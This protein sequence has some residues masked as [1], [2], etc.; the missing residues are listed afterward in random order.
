[1]SRSERTE[2]YDGPKSLPH[3]LIQ[4]MARMAC[5]D[6]IPH[7]V[8]EKENA[9]GKLCRHYSPIE[10]EV[11]V[12]M[13]KG[14]LIATVG[15]TWDGEGKLLQPNFVPGSD[16]ADFLRENFRSA[17]PPH[18]VL[19]HTRSRCMKPGD[20][21]GKR[22]GSRGGKDKSHPFLVVWVGQCAGCDD[23][24]STSYVAGF[25]E[26]DLEA[27]HNESNSVMVE[28]TMMIRGDGCVHPTDKKY[29]KLS[30]SSRMK[31][32]EK[33]R[34]S[35]DRLMRP[36]ALA[37]RTMMEINDVNFTVGNLDG[38]AATRQ[39]EYELN[40]EVK[41]LERKKWN[42]TDCQLTNCLNVCEKLKQ[43]DLDERRERDGDGY[44]KD[45]PGLVRSSGFDDGFRAEL[46]TK[47]SIELFNELLQLGFI[48]YFDGS[49]GLL[50][51]PGRGHIIHSRLS[52]NPSEIFLNYEDFQHSNKLH[53]SFVLA[54]HISEAQTGDVFASFF[55]S[56]KASCDSLTQGK[57][58][59]NP[60]LIG[61]DCAGQLQNGLIK[62]YARDGQA[63]T[64]IMWQNVVLCILRWWER[65]SEANSN[66]IETSKIAFDMMMKYVPLCVHECRS[67]VF[68]AVDGWP[69]DKKRP[70]DVTNLGQAL[71]RM[72]THLGDRMTSHPSICDAIAQLSYSI[73]ILEESHIS[74]PKFDDPDCVR[75]DI[76]ECEIQGVL[77]RMKEHLRMSA[78]L[79]H[80]HTRS[81]LRSTIKRAMKS[82]NKIKSQVFSGVE[83]AD[84]VL[85]E[86]KKTGIFVY[87]YVSSLSD[88][89][90]AATI[91]Y[92]IIYDVLGGAERLA[93]F[94]SPAFEL[95]T[96][97]PFEGGLVP[98]PLL[99][100]TAAKYLRKTWLKE[101]AL[102][103]RS[104]VNLLKTATGKH[105][106]DNNQHS[107]G[108]WRDTKQQPDL[109]ADCIEPARYFL[110][111][112][113]GF[114]QSCRM[115]VSDM[116]RMEI[117]IDNRKG[118][119]DDRDDQLL[120][121]SVEMTQDAIENETLMT[122]DATWDTGTSGKRY[123]T[124]LI[125]ALQ[126][127]FASDLGMKSV[128]GVRYT[129]GYDALK[130][131]VTLMGVGHLRGMGYKTFS[132]WMK[133]KRA[134]SKNVGKGN[135]AAFQDYIDKH[136]Q[137][138]GEK[139]KCLGCD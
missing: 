52:F 111:R 32:I 96:D 1:M 44:C 66:G 67:H 14:D 113:E 112:Y 27:L 6:A 15:L 20:I 121:E 90:N 48:G 129:A 54:E 125:W 24:C 4:K 80:I 40:R 76:D 42:L 131:H 51:L 41:E 57:E 102:W 75:N 109:K 74:L 139:C 46:Y 37:K 79:L 88:E 117:V 106:Y 43:I 26:G 35:A 83:V 133:G 97:Y 91:R 31:A 55:A 107:E 100:S 132:L 135:L 17:V 13:T 62:A 23:G 34:Y 25:R 11:I 50:H 53:V 9:S 29:G 110:R 73:C 77:E 21:G 101:A 92:H 138:A 7:F 59:P 12:K 2:P 3:P 122:T 94:M 134:A 36:S 116:Q 18:I 33:R 64:R 58:S 72:F 70:A 136:G 87:A 105:I 65:E 22:R 126:V 89:K 93:P 19:K 128:E 8:E 28:F 39:Q 124:K 99:C 118:K 71:K 78:S 30:K 5:D 85:K 127:I 104:A 60:L 47:V 95:E 63:T 103:S 120:E 82:N 49:G 108:G 10:S 16:T 115:L 119:M 98:N 81:E 68:R 61:T 38:I 137:G 84:P 69:K 130:K 123:E 56:L 45:M 114:Q 86:H